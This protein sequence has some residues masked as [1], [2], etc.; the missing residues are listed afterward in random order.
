MKRYPRRTMGM[1]G[2]VVLLAGGLWVVRK[3]S[4][5]VPD[6][7]ALRL[8]AEALAQDALRHEIARL[9]A[10][11][12]A[13]T[14]AV[15]RTLLQLELAQC[16]LDVLPGEELLAGEYARA[17]LDSSV[18]EAEAVN[19]ALI[20]A[21]SHRNWRYERLR[22]YTQVA[23]DHPGTEWEAWAKVGMARTLAEDPVGGENIP[24]YQCERAAELLEE[25]AAQWPGTECARA[26][27][28]FLPPI[29][30]YF[31][32]PQAVADL[33]LIAGELE[34]WQIDGMMQ[35][36]TEM[37]CRPGVLCSELAEWI[38]HTAAT[39]SPRVAAVAALW[40]DALAMTVEEAVT[41]LHADKLKTVIKV[42]LVHKDVLPEDELAAMRALAPEMVPRF[43]E[44]NRAW[45]WIHAGREASAMGDWAAT[46]ACARQALENYYLYDQKEW[47]LTA[48]IAIATMAWKLGDDEMGIDVL[49]DALERW[50][51]NQRSTSVLMTLAR[52]YDRMGDAAAADT[53]YARLLD[54]FPPCRGRDAQADWIRRRLKRLEDG[55]P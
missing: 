54:D 51:H 21:E 29:R 7:G 32:F 25:V 40:A 26:A 24:G 49:H 4:G 41:S 52:K 36:M 53:L 5:T 2:L 27:L 9:T 33:E 42:R 1:I 3:V 6:Y 16:H 55:G 20:L 30:A 34:D 12:A 38:G 15:E 19:A 10:A 37:A 17:V 35:Q 39:A 31:D 44:R 14:D 43:P 28:H 23:D 18:A 13:E 45:G 46:V 22:L 11:L 47:S 48:A 50:P 8:E